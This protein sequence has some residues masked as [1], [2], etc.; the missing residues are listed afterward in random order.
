VLLSPAPAD[1]TPPAVWHP[2]TGDVAPARPTIELLDDTGSS[3][4]AFAQAGRR[5][6]LGETWQ[7]YRIR[8]VNPTGARV[9][10]VVSVDGL[11]AI[12]GKPAT[13]TKRGYL[14]PAHGEVVVDGWRTSLDTVA[15]F[16]FSTVPESYAGLTGHEQNV[17]V[18]GVAFFRE[19]PAPPPPPP[20]AWRGRMPVPSASPKASAGAGGGGAGADAG[21][22]RMG[23]G[24]QFGE[25]HESHI[26]E[27]SFERADARPMAVS[28]LRY[29]DRAG[30]LARGIH[31]PPRDE[32]DAE[33]DRRDRAQPFAESRF[34][35]SPR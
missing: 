12:D 22:G 24:T 10:A 30:L 29:D 18:I 15:A 19:Q 6:V 32:R 33:N 27:V 8:I 1:A 7:R 31:L 11:D 9:E 26:R 23:L 25:S 28:E 3:L 14:V 13:T 34:A 16:R 35:H 5:F 17:G 21:P 20:I 2:P 4:P